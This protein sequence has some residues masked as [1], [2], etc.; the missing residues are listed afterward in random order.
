MAGVAILD[1][2]AL[3]WFLEGNPRLGA[4]ARAVIEDPDA[5]LLLPSIALAEALHVVA[6]GRTSIPSVSD[7]LSDVEADH[8]IAVA[9]LDQA[10]VA[11]SV[12]LTPL[13]EMPDRLIVATALHESASGE[14]VALLTC[15]T[16]I[17][18][19]GLVPIVW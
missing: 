13:P 15:D 9:T 7:L 11:L 5:R 8:R 3:I 12:T 18:N 1:A 2:H 6:R 10:I 4:A 16:A 19:S 14:P 17:V